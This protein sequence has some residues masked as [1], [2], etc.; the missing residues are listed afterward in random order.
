MGGPA[1]DDLKMA[2]GMGCVDRS[3]FMPISPPQRRKRSISHHLVVLALVLVTSVCLGL[4]NLGGTVVSFVQDRGSPEQAAT[5]L[6]LAHP[7]I[8]QS[9]RPSTFSFTSTASARKL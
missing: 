9:L 6:L 1:V 7:L 5:R 8:G 3:G 4:Y 2:K